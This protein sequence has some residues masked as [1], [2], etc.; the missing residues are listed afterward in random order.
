[1]NEPVNVVIRLSPD[2]REITAIEIAGRTLKPTNGPFIV[3]KEPMSEGAAIS[4]AE[5][6][7]RSRLVQAVME[8]PVG[9]VVPAEATVGKDWEP[10]EPRFKL[11]LTDMAKPY[12]EDRRSKGE[13]R[14]PDPRKL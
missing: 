5:G 8:H 4:L 3:L 2:R 12:R 1:M 11:D 6:V 14:W 9:A 7:R 10:P 13:R